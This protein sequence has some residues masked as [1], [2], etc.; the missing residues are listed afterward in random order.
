MRLRTQAFLD[1]MTPLGRQGLTPE[2]VLA[3]LR[4]ADSAHL[5]YERGKIDGRAFHRAQVERLGLRLGYDEWMRAWNAYF[6]PNRPME[7]LLGRLQ[8][9][10]RLWAL[11]NTNAEHLAHVRLNYRLF[12]TFEGF[13]ASHRVGT[14]KPDPAIFR[15]AIQGLGLPP[16]EI[17]YLDDVAAF[18]ETGRSLGLRGF[19][20]TYNDAALQAQLEALGVPLDPLGGASVLAC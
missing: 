20:Y 10:L 13:S 18:V 1:R 14:R 11:S 7:A 12:D 16:S 2:D 4:E 5:D 15:H 17:L 9:R 19:H 6:E 8:G 3:S